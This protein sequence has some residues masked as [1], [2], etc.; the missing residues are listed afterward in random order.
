MSSAS[1]SAN[2]LKEL[3]LSI[4]KLRFNNHFGKHS[5]FAAADR[6]A[7]Y[8]HW[9]GVPALLINVLLGSALFGM[10]K[11]NLPEYAPLIGGLCAFLAAALGGMQTLFHFKDSAQGH[12]GVANKYLALARRCEAVLAGYF[13]GEVNLQELNRRLSELNES[14]VEVNKEAESLPL[15]PSD[16]KK[17]KRAQKDSDT[18]EPSA[19]QRRMPKAETPL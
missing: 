12:R 5:H 16:F 8:H 9:L 13:D 4:E 17:S 2:E 19:V 7:R 11:T 6:K 1:S 3:V 10:F 14:Y 18:K 15:A